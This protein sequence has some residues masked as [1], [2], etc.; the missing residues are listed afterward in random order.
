M[1][2]RRARAVD[3][4]PEEFDAVVRMIRNNPELQQ[5]IEAITGQS[6]DGKS[7]REVFD[8]FRTI[9]AVSG[10]QAVV[11][12]Y[13]RARQAVRDTRASLEADANAEE[14]LRLARAEI[15]R[16][17]KSNEDLK[18]R[19]QALSTAHGATALP[20]ARTAGGRA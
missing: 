13:G 16:L 20:P 5:D 3:Y 18:R 9:E 4:S 7:A 14:A 11:V 8:L 17:E 2:R 10:V 19:N 12:N 1:R 6:L 15:T